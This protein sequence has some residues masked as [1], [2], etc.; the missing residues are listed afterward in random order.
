MRDSKA[1]ERAQAELERQL[2]EL[3]GLRNASTRD[4]GF[5]LW[6]QTTL[7]VLQRTW[8]GDESRAAKFRRV[9][10][11]PPSARADREEIRQWYEKGCGEAAT[12][13]R[14]LIQEVAER[15]VVPAAPTSEASDAAAALDGLP[16]DSAPMLTLGEDAP[17]K[18]EAS[19]KPASPAPRLSPPPVPQQQRPRKPGEERRK[20]PRR[21]GTG[22]VRLKDMLGFA[23]TNDAPAV[24]DAPRA[25]AHPPRPAE[26]Q[27]PAGARPK[28]DGPA[29][30]ARPADTA[31]P[32]TR[33]AA[34]LPPAPAPPEFQAPPEE[35]DETAHLA[36]PEAELDADDVEE[37]SAP[38]IDE[39][40]LQRALEAALHSFVQREPEPQPPAGDLLA[41]SPVFEA[42][43]RPATRRPSQI[44]SGELMFKS[45]T[46][47][48][49]GAIADE[50]AAFGVPERYRAIAR[51]A[52]L[53]L[54]GH[55]DRRDLTWQ[56]LRESIHFVME[57][58]ILAR[59][60]LPLLLPYLDEAA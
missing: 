31:L 29:A 18:D 41:T 39:G 58:P 52:M 44:N 28:S 40:T 30:T 34:A 37:H 35:I 10:F 46:A 47:T 26:S 3:S 20:R 16:E 57:Y 4:S 9:P 14:D 24:E 59:R 13:L 49:V 23:D 45:S 22:K 5:K 19:P 8:E 56:T 11:S 50:V 1:S 6:R 43:Q 21:Y 53:D 60:I 48:A 15:G 7:T 25:P 55:L 33:G 12:L 38:L 51:A 17:E 42:K 32:V 2:V 36:P 27:R 54:A